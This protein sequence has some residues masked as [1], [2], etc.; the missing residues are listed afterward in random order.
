MTDNIDKK[1]MKRA[2]ELAAKS[3]GYVNPNPHVGAVIVKDGR[4]I[5]EGRH[6]RYG[7]LHAERNALAAVT[8]DPRGAT[9]YVTLEPCCHYGKTPPCTEAIM[10]AGI[11]KV[12]I[13]SDDPNPLVAGKGAGILRDA[14][15]EVI[16]QFMKEECDKLNPS[17]FHYITTGLPYVTLKYA[18]TIDGKIAAS[19]G[20][21]QWITGPAA[22]ARVHEERAKH[23]GIMVGIGTVLKDDPSLNVRDAEGPDPVRII[24]DSRLRTPLGSKV[25]ETAALA[26]KGQEP[27]ETVFTAG[28]TRYPRTIIATLVDDEEK[29]APYKAAGCATILC[30]D[31]GSGHID[32]PDLM[33]KL[34][35][36]KVDSIFMEGGSEA[37]WGALSS[38]IVDHVQAFI[39]PKLFGGAGSK[40]P[41][42]GAGVPYPKDAIMLKDL[43]I[44]YVGPDILVQGDIERR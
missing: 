21:S 35:K 23:T 1:Y 24:L 20:E 40:S 36:M 28:D 31:D 7:Q 12:I 3:G 11:A 17:F 19:T 5:G 13:G 10:E 39:A 15:I 30:E 34:G 26:P 33:K 18:M 41:V 25:V 27:Q 22:R 16:E 32:L 37:A 43:T 14:G 6:E 4:V 44:E 42:G 29:L 2:I 9:M 38:G 8:E